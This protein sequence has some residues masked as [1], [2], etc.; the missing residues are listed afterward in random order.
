MYKE[1]FITTFYPN[2]QIKEKYTHIDGIMNGTYRL[3][4]NKV[5]R[6]LVGCI[7]NKIYQFLNMYSDKNM[8]EYC[9]Y[10]DGKKD[11]FCL[12]WYLN[13]NVKEECSYINGKKSGHYGLYYKDGS[14]WLLCHYTNGKLNGRYR[15]WYEGGQKWQKCYY[16]DG[17]LKGLYR[18]WHDNGD[19]REET[20]YA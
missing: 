8:M 13:G 10:E 3:Y 7:L 11:G 16:V 17:V 6:S 5:E 1:E 18:T 9:E 19:I 2:G 15:D 12:K 20:N 4:N 14:R